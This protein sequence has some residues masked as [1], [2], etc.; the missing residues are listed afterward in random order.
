MEG[1]SGKHSVEVWLID[2]L[3]EFVFDN[4]ELKRH[5]HRRGGKQF[6]EMLFVRFV[7]MQQDGIPEFF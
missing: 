4:V 5:I 3:E 2:E 7:V 1:S 6:A